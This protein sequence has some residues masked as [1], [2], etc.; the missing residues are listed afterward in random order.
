MPTTAVYEENKHLR[1]TPGELAAIVVEPRSQ[2]STTKPAGL[3]HDQANR[4]GAGDSVNVMFN[5]ASA[6][7]RRVYTVFVVVENGERH[8]T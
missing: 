2:A 1:R 6:V 7:R 5:L 8:S 3:Q 4:W